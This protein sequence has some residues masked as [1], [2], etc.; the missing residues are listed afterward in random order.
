MTAKYLS[1]GDAIDYAAGS[2]IA[3]GAMVSF[4]VRV[5]VAVSSILA[6]R[7]GV[8]VVRGV[9]ASPKLSSDVVAVGAN[10]YWDAGNSRLTLS[11][12]GNVRAGYAARA[13]GAGATSIEI[14]INA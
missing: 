1:S 12:S 3:S 6:G 4:G 13:A 2:D 14:N 5:G 8:L 9:F 7:T 10:L 11:D